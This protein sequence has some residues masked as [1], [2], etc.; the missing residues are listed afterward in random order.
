MTPE[1]IRRA[2]LIKMGFT[3]GKCGLIYDDGHP[4]DS[5]S[6]Y[7]KPVDPSSVQDKCNNSGD[8]LYYTFRWKRMARNFTLFRVQGTWYKVRGPLVD[9]F[10]KMT[11]IEEG[12]QGNIQY[13]K[14]VDITRQVD[15]F[16]AAEKLG[17]PPPMNTT[18]KR[19]AKSKAFVERIKG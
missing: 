15:I 14:P 18:Q 16:T 17:L 12:V 10:L 4:M 2:N 19:R 8:G 13:P 11:A 3:C 1:E 7:A 6:W 9:M 5:H